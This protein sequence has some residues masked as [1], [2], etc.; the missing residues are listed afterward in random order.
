MSLQL[1]KHFKCR[2]YLENKKIF[3]D[4][5]IV[6][7]CVTAKKIVKKI[8]YVEACGHLLSWIRRL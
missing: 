7:K 6:S 1:A 5:D 8:Y 4:K 2:S 3:K